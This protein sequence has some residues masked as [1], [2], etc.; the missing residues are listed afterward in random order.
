MSI[1]PTPADGRRLAEAKVVFANGLKFEGWIDRLV[2]S[3]GT[4]ATVVEAAKGVKPL[5]GEEHGHGH[6]HA[7]RRHRSPCLAERRAT[8]R[9]TS[10]TS[11]TRLIAA[12]PDGRDAYEANAAAYLKQLDALDAEVKAALR[13]FP[14]DRR[15]IITSHDA[16]RYFEAAYGIDFV[17][18][19]GVS[20]D[21]EASAKDVARIIQQIR[22]EK[23]PAVFVENISDPR[24]M[25]RIAKETGAKIGDRLYSDALSEPGR[26][27][28]H[29]H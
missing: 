4:K 14:A 19:Q 10:P 1:R 13:G 22:R 17:A 29:L 16:F 27:G 15:K 3:S 25:E 9:S 18:P 5:K 21:A 20:T 7:P 11:A 12:D 24:L 2:K 26:P 23:I 28:R 6:G 8:P